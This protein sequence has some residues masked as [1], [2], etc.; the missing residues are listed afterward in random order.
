[1]ES[2]ELVKEVYAR[3]GLAYYYGECLHKQLCNIYTLGGYQ[4][5]KS[6][7]KPRVDEKLKYAYS[8]TLGNLKNEVLNLI[9]DIFHESLEMAVQKRNFLAHD[10]WF[11]RAHLFLTE[12]GKIEMINELDEHANCY[13][14]L[15]IHLTN[16]FKN[17]FAD[18]GLNESLL[19]ESLQSI[20]NGEIPEPLL[21]KR[22][23]KK[24]EKIIAV[25]EQ[26]LSNNAINFIFETD[27]KELWQLCDVGLG[28]TEHKKIEPEWKKSMSISKYLPSEIDPRPQISTP[29]N[30]DFNLTKNVVLKIR[31]TDPSKNIDYFIKVE[32]TILKL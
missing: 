2:E 18:L 15:D 12:E 21:S 10:F 19:E 25:W 24:K 23:F 22:K 13:H 20:L 27:D 16:E 7:T 17:K 3:F 28:W 6:M 4:S 1:M 30:Y 26:P 31:R 11:E 32:D 29:W 14:K 5:L 8:L 9:P